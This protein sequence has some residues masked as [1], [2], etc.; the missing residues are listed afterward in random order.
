MRRACRLSEASA[1]WLAQSLLG[2]MRDD[3]LSR[4]VMAAL[5]HLAQR[6]EEQATLERRRDGVDVPQACMA[7]TRALMERLRAAMIV[8]DASQSALP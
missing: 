3:D 1:D 4:E 5:A 7:A 8:R 2:F 6:Q